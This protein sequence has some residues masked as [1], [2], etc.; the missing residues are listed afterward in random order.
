MS[1]R[2]PSAAES[3]TILLASGSFHDT[4]F[5]LVMRSTNRVSSHTFIVTAESVNPR[6]S[7]TSERLSRRVKFTPLGYGWNYRL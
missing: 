3:S 2:A 6:A 7:C 1:A 5:A 4:R